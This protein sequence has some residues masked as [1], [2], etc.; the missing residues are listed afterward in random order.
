MQAINELG[1]DVS[2][3][4]LVVQIQRGKRRPPV[5]TFD[6]DPAGH[7]QLIRWA[8]Q[9]GRS[10]RVG[11]EA[12]G[13]YSLDLAL[14]LHR[15]PRIEVM[16]IN[17]RASR[18]FA[19]AMMKRA[20]TDP[21]D[22]EVILEFVQR[23][24]FVSWQPPV[25]EVLQL[26][27]ITRRGYQLKKAINQ[28]ANRLHADGF[29]RE[30]GSIVTRDLEVNIRHLKRRVERLER[31]GRQLIATVPDLEDKFQRLLSIKG[32]GEASAL[33]ILA[34]VLVL[35]ADLQPEQWVAQ[36]GLDP[37]PRESGSSVHRL[38]FISKAGNKYLRAALYMPA[39]VAIRFQINVEAFYDKLI[40]A[41]KKPM[42]AIIAV[43]RKLL[44]C[45]WAMLKYD[46]DFVG[47]KFY[48]LA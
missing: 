29:R 12:T 26:Q 44:R 41:G 11:L 22:A 45:I 47:D 17:P 7:A 30:L 43:M 33:H 14:A 40:D 23:M 35:P 19:C 4:S 24:P 32:I 38:R 16:V 39:L 2:A 10:A 42:Q 15:H 46:Q 8:T 21:V 25:E 6:N 13:I 34:E 20:K 18:H 5:A 37:R 1:I 3:K 28:E 9:R 48:V 31:Q 27:A 36:A